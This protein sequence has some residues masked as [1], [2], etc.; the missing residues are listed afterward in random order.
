M[1]EYPEVELLKQYCDSTCLHQEIESVELREKIILE[2]GTIKEF[3]RNL[4]G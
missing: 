1:P 4:V 3:E 2:A